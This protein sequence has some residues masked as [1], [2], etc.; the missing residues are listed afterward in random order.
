MNL[1]MDKPHICRFNSPASQPIARFIFAHG[2]GAGM[3]HEFMNT[4]A[5]KL[6]AQNVEVVR[7]NFPYMQLMSESG[8]RRPPNRMPALLEAY[9]EFV[10]QFATDLPLFIGGKSMGGRASTM[11]VAEQQHPQIKGVM[12]LGYPFH[13]A[14]KPEKLRIAHLPDMSVDALIVQGARDSLGNK[15]EVGT[16]EL[17]DK[18]KMAFLTDGDHSLK[19]R[20]MSGVSLEQNL[21][22]ACSSMLAFIKERI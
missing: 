22:R 5:A 6:A 4:M 10:A 20:K 18:V 17:G 2:A 1:S 7:F 21:D 12:V 13:P 14:G 8:Q 16:Y 15:S 11:L 19:P 9:A 3:D